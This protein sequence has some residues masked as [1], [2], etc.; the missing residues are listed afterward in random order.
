M[1]NTIEKN[2]QAPVNKKKRIRRNNLMQLGLGLLVIILLNIIGSYIFTR[3]DLTAEKRYTLSDAT[4]KFLT[5]L[6]D[7]VY[8][9][10][11]LEG[12]FPAGFKRLRNSTREMLD[13][14]RAYSDNIQ[15]KFIN[16]SESKDK[17]HT[18]DLYKQLV[19]KGLEPTELNVNSTEGVSQQI[20]FP[21]AIVSYKGRE[22]PLQ[23]LMSQRGVDPENV[24]NNSI[25]GLEYNLANVIR[26]LSVVTKQKIAFIEGH[27]ELDRQRIADIYYSLGEYYTVEFVTINGK[28]N[29]L[30][31]RDTIRKKL[32]NKY[33]A[34]IIAKPDSAFPEKDKF[35]IDQYVMRGGKILWF[36]D[37]VFASMDS[38]QAHSE[39][40][41]FGRSLN[42]DDM[43]F[44][45]GTRLNPNLVLD[46]SCMKIPIV[47][48][49]YGGQAQQSF[50]P[51]YYFPVIMPTIK[52]PIVSNLNSISTE[53]ISSIDTVGSPDIHKTVLLTT[54]KYSRLMNT[55][56]RISL[57]IMGQ[58]LDEQYFN[59]SY[60]P[61]AVLLEGRFR[62]LFLN[63]VPQE[64]ME[65]KEKYDFRPEIAKNQMLVVSDGDMIKNQ[66]HY[67][68][69][70]PLP[71]GYDQYTNQ[72]FGNK[73]FIL[74]AVD[75][76]CDSSGL[77]TVRSREQRIRLLDKT[78]VDKNKT[79]I[80]FFN[81]ALPVLLVLV[82]GAI[83]IFIRHKKFTR[84][85]K[86]T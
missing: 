8:F 43:L 47:T 54:S 59:R 23:L 68:K 51:W 61:V 63:R 16:P 60:V 2:M 18:Q 28:L 44:Q 55:P 78:Y 41:G 7:V 19:S 52:H 1:E 58:K 65:D 57:D 21:G 35:M 25:V 77:I 15:Y 34:I 17:K 83:W 56:C 46:M 38:L 50:F 84:I 32:I 79:G 72:M 36:L 81:I 67:S 26:K 31:I 71:L 62:S 75:Y 45:Y 22:M 53:F 12:D 5:N 66:L 64:I 6:D 74:N 49:E 42:L 13:E 11:Y 85:I 73:D 39:T 82:F 29:S 86:R 24:L 10:V 48:G 3:F 33:D 76:L 14:F 70:Y 69:G 20:I 37:P 30:S 9:Q 4:K 40:V 27:G 80:Q